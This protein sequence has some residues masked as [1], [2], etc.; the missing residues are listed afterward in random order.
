VFGAH[1]TGVDLITD[2]GGDDVIL[3]K[4]KLSDSNN[5]GIVPTHA[6]LL[7]LGGLDAVFLGLGHEGVRYL[8]VTADGMYAYGDADTRPRN[9]IEGKLSNDNLSGDVGDHKSNVFFFDTDLALDWGSDHITRFGAKDILVTTTALA[10]PNHD[11]LIL[12][13]PGSVFDFTAPANSAPGTDNGS[14]TINNTSG[15]VVSTL[16]FDG[17]VSHDG[18]DYYIYSLVGSSGGVGSIFF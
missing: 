7:D 1:S 16:E 3:T 9:A 6:G 13:G 12:A 4:S 15:A 10:D 17:V 5:D 11:N 14:V 8:G 2:F 18:V